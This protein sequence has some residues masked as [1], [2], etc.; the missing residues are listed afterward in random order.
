LLKDILHDG[1]ELDSG[2]CDST[3][4]HS[5]TGASLI[6][7]SEVAISGEPRHYQ[8]LDNLSDDKPHQQSHC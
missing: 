4:G 6:E 3:M 5:Q 1:A 8:V 7:L 2:A